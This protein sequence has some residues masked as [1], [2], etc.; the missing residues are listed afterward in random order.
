MR[1]RVSLRGETGTAGIAEHADRVQFA[2]TQL[3]VADS[4]D[5]DA[6]S[7]L[8]LRLP[9]GDVWSK[10]SCGPVMRASLTKLPHWVPESS[11]Q[12]DRATLNVFW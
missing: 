2:T 1:L 11:R 9:N 4:E 3:C 6:D 7:G 8:H 10:W 12:C 5:A